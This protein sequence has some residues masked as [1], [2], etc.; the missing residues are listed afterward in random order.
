MPDATPGKKRW[1]RRIALVLVSLLSVGYVAI[2]VLMYQAQAEMIFHPT[3]EG[4]VMQSLRD[5]PAN[6][7]FDLEREGAELH[8]ALVL[9]PGE[10]P[11][12]LLIYF[13]GN[14]EAVGHKAETFAWLKEARAH[15][16]FLP[17]RGYDGST[18]A[19]GADELR[20]DSL[21]AFDAAIAN[22]RV[23]AT[24]V[25][26]MG[27][28]LGSGLASHLAHQRQL[29]GVVLVA[30]FRRLGELAE[31]SYPWLPVAALLEHD[32]DTLGVAPETDEKLLVVHGT[33]DTMIPIEH[34]RDVVSAW[35][36]PA[37]LL[38]LD[39]QGHNGS[40]GDPRTQRAVRAFMEL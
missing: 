8:G 1:F 21:A 30:P 11:A 7:S 4:A 36:G 18:G 29:A 16:L 13:G 39:G 27:Y 14:A 31:G 19:P 9:A 12:P 23:D 2:C 35:K 34:G 37:E 28:S 26:A 32:F 17:Y 24:R 5:D 6:E 15:L 20:A 22:P 10:A 40:S 33:D 3:H 38:V 25:Y